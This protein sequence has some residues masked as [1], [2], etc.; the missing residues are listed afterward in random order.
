[1]FEKTAGGLGCAYCH[2]LDASGDPAIGAPNIR[3]VTDAQIID[4]LN[5]RVQMSFLNLTNDEITA[6]AAYLMTLTP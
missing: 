2:Q 3:G 5:T 1:M 4:A 6:V